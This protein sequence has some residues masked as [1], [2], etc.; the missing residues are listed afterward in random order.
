MSN[1]KIGLNCSGSYSINTATKQFTKSKFGPK[2]DLKPYVPGLNIFLLP[3]ISLALGSQTWAS[4]RS[5]WTSFET[6]MADRR[7]LLPVNEN[8]LLSFAI[9]LFTVRKLR[10]ASVKAYVSA[11]KFWHILAKVDISAFSSPLV[12]L[13]LDGIANADLASFH[14]PLTRR[15]MTFPSLTLLGD[16]I[17]HDDK[18]NDEDKTV[19]WI[20]CLIGWWASSRLGSILP[21]NASSWDGYKALR[22]SDI[23]VVED[24]HITLH[25]RLPKIGT[26]K[27]GSI[28]DLFSYKDTRYC[29]IFHLKK[30]AKMRGLSSYNNH[31]EILTFSSGDPIHMGYINR[32]LRRWMAPFVSDGRSFWSCHSFRNANCFVLF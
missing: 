26:V 31:E 2:F 6:F 19:I 10:A 23:R 18:L 24:G 15:V 12:K 11:I 28:F 14:S 25:V 5:A 17:S 20:T 29:P 3:W 4:Y 27:G 32:N 16:Q 30:L 13:V 9:H 8:V 1:V 7:P 22:W 21:T